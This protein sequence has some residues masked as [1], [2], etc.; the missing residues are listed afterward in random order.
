MFNSKKYLAYGNLA[1]VRDKLK[2]THTAIE[3]I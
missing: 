3:S 1:Q 2:I